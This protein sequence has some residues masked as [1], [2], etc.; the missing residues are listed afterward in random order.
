M[1]TSS[2]GTAGN[3]S[4]VAN[5]TSKQCIISYI[6]LKYMSLTIYYSCI[7]KIKLQNEIENTNI[8]DCCCVRLLS[9]Q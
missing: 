2:R 3:L 6:S 5:Q 1:M 7:G 9:K 4:G 8:C